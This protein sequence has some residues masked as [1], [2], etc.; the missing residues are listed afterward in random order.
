MEVI[1]P[2]FFFREA[3][4]TDQ[5]N[6]S[7]QW[8]N[9]NQLTHPT[10]TKHALD[11]DA[12]NKVPLRDPCADADRH[13][14]DSVAQHGGRDGARS[15]TG[16]GQGTPGMPLRGQAQLAPSPPRGA[17]SGVGGRDLDVFVV[18]Q[19]NQRLAAA[20]LG[21]GVPPGDVEI[22]LHWEVGLEVVPGK[23][24]GKPTTVACEH[25]EGDISLS[26]SVNRRDDR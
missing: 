16:A 8:R 23:V 11:V 5:D 22:C 25:Q 24:E 12:S 1:Q 14:R 26:K 13:A 19:V 17:R 15:L 18:G 21:V 6:H 9:M 10:D 2:A 3:C 7:H 20:N 4:G